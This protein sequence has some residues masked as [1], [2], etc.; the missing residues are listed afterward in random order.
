MGTAGPRSIGRC[1]KVIPLLQE[2]FFEDWG[3]VAAVLGQPPDT[4][5][6]F[7][8]CRKLKDPSGQIGDDRLSWSVRS[9]FAD[10]AFDRMIAK[11]AAA[12]PAEDSE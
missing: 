7:L 10:D 8:D 2:Y 12:A 1:A 6:G 3:R 9:G 5:G 4:G 11:A